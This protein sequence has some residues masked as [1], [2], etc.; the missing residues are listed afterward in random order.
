MR[1]RGGRIAALAAA[2]TLG[3]AGTAAAQS[4]APYIDWPSLLPGLP[5]PYTP[6]VEPDCADGSDGCIDHTITEMQRR[7]NTVVPVCDHRAV[8]S[9]AYLRVTEDV[10]AGRVAGIFKDPKWLNSEDAVFARLYF[11]VYDAYAAGRRDGIPTAW[12][13]AFDSE[14]DRELS[15]L[16]DFLMSMN[17]HINR[18]MP[19]VLAGIGITKPDGTTRKPDHDVYN[20]RLAA[21]YTPVLK[22]VA[23]RFDPTADDIEL[24]PVDDLAAAAILQTWR[25]GVWRNA[26]RLANATTPAA[27]AD[28]A[29]SIEA[30]A[31]AIGSTLR[32]VFRADPGPRDAW[33]A[34]HGGQDPAWTAA[35]SG[36]PAGGVRPAARRVGRARLT[37][38]ALRTAAGARSVRVRLSCPAGTSGCRGRLLL[39]TPHGGPV[40][41]SRAYT[42]K[43]GAAR[44]LTL[45]VPALVRPALRQQRSLRLT[46]TRTGVSGRDAK[47]RRMVRVR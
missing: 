6:N 47:T 13:L 32:A 36:A 1:R 40:L 46:L 19:F 12:L 37:G 24:G 43:A 21:L 11:D 44:A 8:F 7:L 30:L 10:K 9:L 14:R 26:E 35:G 2:L 31:T 41:D 17:A 18:D 42:L 39:Q 15:A 29:A 20:R 45:T 28:V 38:G 5:A 4:G 3:T 33:C 34:A 23:T 27:R 25:E 22:E 16:G